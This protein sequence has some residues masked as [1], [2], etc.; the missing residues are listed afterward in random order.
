MF[1]L[2]LTLKFIHVLAVITWIGGTTA[3]AIWTFHAAAD[4]DLTSL[5]VTMRHAGFYGQRVVGPSSGFVLL[6][7]IAMV[8][9]AKIPWSTP[10]IIWGLTGIG[11]HLVLGFAV[12][13][14]NAERIAQLAV[15]PNPDRAQLAAAVTKQKTT[16]SI[17][18]L[19]MAS[20]VWAMV[21]KP[22]F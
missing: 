16:A 7:G 9:S 1:T 8:I 21:T 4:T 11:I 15:S 3:M 14:K 12:L 19:I 17:Y 13:A 18:L 10:W 20:V 22:T 2:Y 5:A 6:A